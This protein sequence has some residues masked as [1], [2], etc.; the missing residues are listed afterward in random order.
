MSDSE[1][2]PQLDP[3]QRILLPVA[4]GFMILL[5]SRP[6]SGSLRTTRV[7]MVSIVLGAASFVAFGFAGVVVALKGGVL[8]LLVGILLVLFALG[9]L[10]LGTYGILQRVHGSP[11]G[12]KPSV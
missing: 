7:T 9:S 1:G 3:V 4:D 2:L 10:S 12:G 8:L 11:S 6:P 5:Y